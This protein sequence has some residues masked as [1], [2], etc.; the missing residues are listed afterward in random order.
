METQVESLKS[1]FGDLFAKLMT[2]VLEDEFMEEVGES[3]EFFYD[4]QEGEEYSFNPTEEF[5]FLS[6]F[7]LDDSD[8][9]GRCLMDE[10]LERN[11]E[12][13]TLQEM[14]ICKALQETYLTLL[15]VLD[16]VPKHSM[17]LRDVF[18]GEEFD[19]LE[20][21]GSEGSVKGTLL[22]TRVLKL[23]DHRFLVG[24]GT[25]LDQ[26]VREPLTQY[27]TDQYKQECEE[28]EKLTFKEFLKENGELVN[29]WI[30][31]FEQGYLLQ[32]SDSQPPNPQAPKKPTRGG[33]S[34]G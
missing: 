28:G 15:Q 20:A 21:V 3:L 25:F 26:K 31:A 22:Y 5:L 18:Q 24:A 27:V 34:A 32:T 19:V 17:K 33:G 1:I 10:F 30:R 14:Q 11:S 4:L 13:L 7:L 6:W 2:F 9:E 29:H 16:V 8:A 12:N 23:G